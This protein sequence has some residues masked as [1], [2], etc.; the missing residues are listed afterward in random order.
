[1]TIAGTQLEAQPFYLFRPL[2]GAVRTREGDRSASGFDQGGAS[3]E[4]RV[5]PARAD[6]PAYYNW[7]GLYTDGNKGIG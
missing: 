5:A 6:R 2:S 4:L 3:C 7:T 1:M